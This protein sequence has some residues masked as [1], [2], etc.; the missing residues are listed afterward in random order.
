MA[1]LNA[2]FLV[3]YCSTHG[4]NN[5]NN[6]TYNHV[7]RKESLVKGNGKRPRTIS[8]STK[9]EDNLEHEVKAL[10]PI[11]IEEEEDEKKIVVKAKG[12]PRKTPATAQLDTSRNTVITRNA[13]VDNKM[14]KRRKYSK[15]TDE[16]QD[17][18]YEDKK[19][20]PIK[21]EPDEDEDDEEE[22]EL[23]EKSKS[24]P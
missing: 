16:E 20:V 7:D 14:S 9:H 11:K 4:N 13:S 2:E 3:H 6:E 8:A 23:K 10:K 24:K 5:A 12:R 21:V 18:D 1:S 22:E 15:K 17:E 19:N